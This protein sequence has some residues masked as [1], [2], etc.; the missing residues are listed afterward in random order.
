MQPTTHLALVLALVKHPPRP[1]S[2]RRLAAW[3]FAL[4]FLE[5]SRSA[6]S[7][8]LGFDLGFS[9]GSMFTILYWVLLGEHVIGD[10]H[11]A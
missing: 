1:W 7:S 6:V 3:F 2:S 9:I 10:G 4:A 8:R 11:E 5:H